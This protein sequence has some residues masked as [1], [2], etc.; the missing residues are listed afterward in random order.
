MATEV[1]NW[2]W[3]RELGRVATPPVGG[4]LFV[5]AVDAWLKIGQLLFRPQTAAHDPVVVLNRAQRDELLEFVAEDTVTIGEELV[6]AATRR[7]FA[8]VKQLRA[9]WR[10]NQAILDALGCDDH[11][12]TG[13]T[14]VLSVPVAA[15]VP[16]LDRWRDRVDGA[17]HDRLIGPFADDQ[18]LSMCARRQI[19]ADLDTRLLLSNLSTTLTEAARA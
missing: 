3:V 2:E 12:D 19:D 5:R 10:S 11:A 4:D 7:D 9:P 17:L 15:M 13:R 16:A 18:P 8:A 1:G 6:H 14:H